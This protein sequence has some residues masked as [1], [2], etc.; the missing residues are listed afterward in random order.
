MKE[1]TKHSF[2][3]Y[4]VRPARFE[5]RDRLEA[6]ISI[7][8]RELS[9]EDYS[10]QEIETAITY[11]FGVDSEV[12]KDGTYYVV[13]TPGQIVAC[14]GWSRRRKPFG[15]DQYHSAS[16]LL[17]PTKD[18]AK[19]RA[20]FVHPD[21]ARRGIA[22]LLLKHCESEAKFHGFS[23]MEMT[24]TL[25]GVKF[26]RQ[27]GYQETALSHHAMPNGVTLAFMPMIKALA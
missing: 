10:E 12:V 18:P 9:R 14:G 13:E 19:I 5:E 4:Q 20:F 23:T 25:P 3:E 8:A 22:S 27:H 26:Y 16:E 6:L 7:S 17:D 21:W 24:A 15:G 1:N 2:R 11:V